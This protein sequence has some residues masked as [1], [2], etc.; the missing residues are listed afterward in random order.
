MEWDLRG[1]KLGGPSGEWLMNHKDEIAKRYGFESFD[2]LLEV[3]K[4]LPKLFGETV[5][6]YLGQHP[7]G[8]WFL[9]QDQPPAKSHES[10]ED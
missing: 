4:P 3:S 5:Q 8:F 2:E 10:S 6:C 9:W 7:R 1:T